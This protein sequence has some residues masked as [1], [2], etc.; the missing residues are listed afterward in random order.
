MNEGVRAYVFGLD[1]AAIYYSSLSVELI[2]FSKLFRKLGKYDKSKMLRFELLIESCKDE[3]I[4]D[5]RFKKMADDIRL[6]RDCY[7]HYSNWLVHT[8]ASMAEGIQLIKSHKDEML[9]QERKEQAAKAVEE[10]SRLLETIFPA[11]WGSLRLHRKKFMDWRQ[12]EYEKWLHNQNKSLYDL[13]VASEKEHRRFGRSK[14]DAFTT[15]Q[16]SLEL[17]Q[18]FC[19]SY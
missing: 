18:F 10:M 2:L 12:K 19:P 7:V 15:M 3:E 6:L 5:E 8:R 14:F 11:G 16:W 13:A 4:L 1:E 9:T 17:L